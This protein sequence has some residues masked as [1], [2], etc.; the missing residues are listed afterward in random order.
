ME[1][2]NESESR[3]GGVREEMSVENKITLSDVVLM[4]VV[5][6]VI[7]F[8][9]VCAHDW[10]CLPAIVVLV[11]VL[12]VLVSKLIISKSTLID[13]AE[14]QVRTQTTYLGVWELEPRVFSDPIA[15]VPFQYHGAKVFLL[16]RSEGNLQTTYLFTLNPNRLGD[17]A[18]VDAAL[19]GS[20]PGDPL[21]VDEALQEPGGEEELSSNRPSTDEQ[22]SEPSL[23]SG[24]VVRALPH[25]GNALL[26]MI[27]LIV[28]S[29]LLSILA[30]SIAG[31]GSFSLP[32]G[33]V[34]IVTVLGT[35]LSPFFGWTS[36]GILLVGYT[37]LYTA[38]V[39]DEHR[40]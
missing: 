37:I 29:L 12:L 9:I 16:H 4:T 22:G 17:L 20:E 33:N 8:L 35:G 28:G 3:R 26:H 18:A 30:E 6:L 7:V 15:L 38:G 13:P 1:A 40:R 24:V 31:G 14:K 36:T 34:F 11:L 39:W 19:R 21:A 27:V 10:G 25:L 5:G 32:F 2:D 23:I